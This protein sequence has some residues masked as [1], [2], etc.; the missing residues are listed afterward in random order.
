MHC[1]DPA[2]GL[3]R[4]EV[5]PGTAPVLITFEMILTAPDV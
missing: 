5:R 1:I 4:G 3:F 2:G